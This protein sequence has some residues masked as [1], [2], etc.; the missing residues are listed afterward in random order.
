M[1]I[2]NEKKNNNCL[3][4]TSYFLPYKTEPVRIKMDADANSPKKPEP[5]EEKNKFN[6]FSIN[7]ENN[8]NIPIFKYLVLD[9]S[10]TDKKRIPQ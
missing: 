10:E 6:A 4:K 1:G 3:Y 7:V 9:K 5:G 2:F 8:K